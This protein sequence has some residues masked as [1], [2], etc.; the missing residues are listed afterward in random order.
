M[1]ELSAARRELVL[2]GTGTSVGVPVIGCDCAVCMSPN[3]RNQRTRTGVAVHAA[4]GTF[5]IDTPPEL[6]LQLVR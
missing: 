1:S 2:L 6:R 5:L 4:E 3:P